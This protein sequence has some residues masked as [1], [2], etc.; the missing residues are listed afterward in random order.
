MQSKQLFDPNSSTYSYLIWDE[1]TQE[2]ALIDSVREQVER[3][4]KLIQELGLN[5][6]FLLETH[7]HADHVTGAGELRKRFEAK[8][9]V[10]RN[11]QST[12]ADQLLEEGDSL[13]LGKQ[14]INVLYTPGHTDTDICYRI[15]GAVFT[16]DTLM[17]RSSGRT[18]FQSGDAGAAYD[19]ITKKLFSL[20]DKTIVWPG[21]D[22]QGLT[23]S[24]I[25]EEKQHNPRLAGKSRQEYIEIMESMDLPKPR[26][27]A[28]S[29]P[30]NLRCGIDK[31]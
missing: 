8:V 14:T 31:S 15:E 19:S 3:D 26:H 27:I 17:I 2:A 12:C 6:H 1:K 21:H 20:E 7:I 9:A 23:Q 13:T 10:H 5:L 11:S 16:G 18:D 25:G 28:E 24:S 30:G 22:Y 29:V 4:S